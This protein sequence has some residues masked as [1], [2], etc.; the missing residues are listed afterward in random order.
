MTETTDT[1]ADTTRHQILRAAAGQFA[2]L[3]YH[4]VGL[5]DVLAEAELTKGAMYF[6]FRSKHALALAI[7]EDHIT[8]SDEAITDLLARKLSGLETLIDFSYQLALR[9][10]SEDM[11][12]SAL[13]LV[14]SIGR[15]E[16]LQTKLH[17]SWIDNLT[18]AVQRG[19]AEGDVLPDCDP[20]EVGRLVASTYMGLR[21]TSNLDEPERFLRD[22]QQTWTLLLPGFVRPERIDYF[23]QFIGRRTTIA[24]AS[25]SAL[26]G[27]T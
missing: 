17:K 22:F 15:V 24:I 21:Q 1:R 25:T 13:H 19:I 4:Q 12:R 27:S 9:D 18:V 23:R 11:S 6:H 16:G 2:R 14:E 8:R 5:D 3:P 7:I 26:T 10:I 20:V